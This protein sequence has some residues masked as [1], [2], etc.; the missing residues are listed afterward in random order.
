MEYITPCGDTELDKPMYKS[1]FN[2]IKFLNNFLKTIISYLNNE[3][4]RDIDKKMTVLYNELKKY[5]T[6][7]MNYMEERQINYIMK[8]NDINGSPKYVYKLLEK[9]QIDAINILINLPSIDNEINTIN[10][11]LQKQINKAEEEAKIEIKPNQVFNDMAKNNIKFNEF[12]F[13][14]RENYKEKNQ[15]N[16]IPDY[17]TINKNKSEGE[18]IPPKQDKTIITNTTIMSHRL[19]D[20]N[21]LSKYNNQIIEVVGDNNDS[22]NGF[23]KITN[24]IPTKVDSYGLTRNQRRRQNKKQKNE[25]H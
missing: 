23:Y 3:K 16:E 8:N 14:E 17:N 1:V 10:E 15:V 24:G 5:N 12:E 25:Q 22:V 7:L 11:K 6:R 21:Y 4:D 2:N 18:S 19:K 9:E 20:S 13:I